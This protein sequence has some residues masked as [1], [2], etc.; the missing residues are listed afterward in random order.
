MRW[1]SSDLIIFDCD[2]TLSLIEGIDE[3]ARLA[4]QESEIAALTKRA[5]DGDIS[6]ES[7]YERRMITVMPSRAQMRAIKKSYRDHVVADAPDVIAALQVLGKKVFIVSGG[8]RDAVLDFGEWLGVP[9]ANIYAVSIAYNQLSGE[10]WQYHKRNDAETYLS[11][12]DDTLAA[13]GGK[14]EV[15]KE[16]RSQHKGRAMLIG[17]GLSD[18]EARDAVDLFVGFGGAVRR[19]RVQSDADVFI[20]TPHLSP[21]LPLAAKNL[22][23]FRNL[24]GLLEDGLKRI[25]TGD[26]TFKDNGMKIDFGKSHRS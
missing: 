13:S 2:S 17:D 26:V 19:A 7:I 22:Q 15:I 16:I 11:I 8:L 25:E 18:L 4:G 3:L 1:L 10:W 20:A 23:G 6:L 24:E 14:I 12:E 9:R 5:M 21:I